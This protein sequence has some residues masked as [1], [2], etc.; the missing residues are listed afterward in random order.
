M[1]NPNKNGRTITIKLNGEPHTFQEEIKEEEK[2][3]TRQLPPEVIDVESNQEEKDVFLETAAAQES[4]DESFDWII[5]ETAEHEI[6]EYKIV[7]HQKNKKSTLPK[8]ASFTTNTKNKDGKGFQSIIISAVFAIILGTGFGFLMLKL[9]LTEHSN[10]PATEQ[11]LTEEQGQKAETPAETGAT[12]SVKPLTTFVIQGGVFSS[13][14]G[15]Q[16]T[17]DQLAEKEVPAQSVEIDGKQYLFLG[18]ASTI[19]DAKKL[20][21]KYKDAGIADVWAKSLS[22]DQKDINGVNAAD[23]TFLDTAGALYQ[24]LTEVTAV[25]LLSE[26]IPEESFKTVSALI[27]KTDSTALKN[28]KVK[29]L[30]NFLATAAEK[31]ANYQ[32]NKDQNNLIEAQ[33]NLLNF[34][35]LYYTL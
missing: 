32:K 33:Q 23:K 6:E 30:Q 3:E 24:D 1:D 13:K 10:K 17:A 16:A 19:D 4:M 34:L 9:V 35:S 18:V 5:P 11:V 14:D 15:A 8:I 7:H 2:I 25:A 31:V 22:V 29:S 27:A 12:A 26:S 20:G 28:T 21:S